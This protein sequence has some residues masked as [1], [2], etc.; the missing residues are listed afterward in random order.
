MVAE[1]VERV[2]EIENRLD[3]F[4]GLSEQD[5]IDLDDELRWIKT[6]LI[7]H[8]TDLV[9]L[10]QRDHRRLGWE[11]LAAHRGTYH[12]AARDKYVRARRRWPGGLAETLRTDP[13]ERR[14]SP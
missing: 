11:E 6:V 12:N 14:S 10:A 4:N 1:L 5:L 2:A 8:V 13:A 3:D 7:P 9:V